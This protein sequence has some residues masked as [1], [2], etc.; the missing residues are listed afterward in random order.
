MFVLCRSSN[1]GAGELQDLALAGAGH[2][3][4]LYEWVAMRAVEWNAAGNVGLVMGATYPQELARVRELAPG[5]PILVPGVGAQSGHLEASVKSG[6]D[7]VH[8]NLLISSS[9]GIAY[10]SRRHRDFRD[11]AREAALQLKER[12][13]RVLS[14]EGREWS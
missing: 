11:A 7:S 6:L 8:P 14:L 12:I 4:T 9:R 10:A 13:E 5:M 2:G 3:R 1:A